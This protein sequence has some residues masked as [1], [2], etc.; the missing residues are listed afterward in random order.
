MT[1]TR[2]YTDG[3]Y[4]QVHYAICGEGN[5]LVL[6][7]QS[8][9]HMIQFQNVWGP[10]SDRGIQAIGIDLPGYG[11]SDGPNEVPS[12]ED[13]ADVVPTVLDALGIDKADILGHH[14]GSMVATEVALQFPDRINRIILNGPCPFGDDERE[15][16][17]PIVANEKNYGPRE[18][19]SHLTEQWNS[20]IGAQPG[21]TDLDA[22]HR[23][24]VAGAAAWPNAWFAH[25]AVI[26]YDHA[27]AMKKI[28]QPCLI[29]SNNG[30]TI[31]AIA[32]RAKEIC[33]H[34]DYS[35]Q[36]GGTFD[37]IDEQPVVWADAVAE[38][39]NR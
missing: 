27:E 30:D 32:A 28:T 3:K 37:F 29:M 7:H 5:P 6:M 20:R 38:W 2:A 36:E 10:L 11:C 12:M 39:L 25:D 19:G 35:E 31:H 23:N 9:T 34:F 24:V 14:T 16:F 8:P 18:D 21:W 1:P 26:N 4:G 17:R 22:I 15:F 13:Y 33:P